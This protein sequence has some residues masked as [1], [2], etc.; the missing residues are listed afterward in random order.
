MRSI[1]SLLLCLSLSFCWGC[2]G[3]F[4]LRGG[5]SG[6][7]TFGRG[8]VAADQV[9][10]SRAGARILAQ[11]GNAVDAAVAASFTLSVV[12]PYSCGIGGGGFMVINLPDD[13]RH[14][15]VVTAINYRE[16]SAVDASYFERTGKSGTRGGAAV[17]IPGTVAGLLMAQEKYGI[18]DR[19]TVLAPAIAAARQG[20]VV[21]DHYLSGARRL[22][23]QF[24]AEP[25]MKRDFPLVW[26][27]FLREGK[28][29]R[30][31][32]ITNPKQ[33]RAL[34]RIADEGRDGF[35]KGIV[36]NSIAA[37]VRAQGGEMTVEDLAGY[38]PIECRPLVRE[39]NGYTFMTMPPPSSGGV[40]MLQTLMILEALNYDFTTA[41]MSAERAHLMAEAFKHAFAD[42]ANYLADPEFVDV[43]VNDLLDLSILHERAQLITDEI[44]D[45]DYYGTPNLAPQD[46]GTSH[47][48][49]VDPY[50]GAVACTETINHTFGSLVGVDPFG[51]V[52]NN[53]M[54]DFT[55]VRNQPN[56]FSLVQ[57]DHNLPAVGK[58]PLSSMSP[59]IVL[60]A[61]GELFA[62]AGASG[63]PRII[64][65]T[66]QTLLGAM[67]GLSAQE[68]VGA[69]RL[70]HQW[71]PDTLYAEPG[72]YGQLLVRAQEG[73]WHTLQRRRDIGNVQ[74]IVR[75]P[76]G[77]GWEA[78][79]DP[80]KGGAPAGID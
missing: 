59:T 77:R 76:R 71:L 30:G 36:A 2:G 62:I 72:L 32:R 22:I 55:T 49:V 26:E 4:N 9:V 80:R 43:P 50:G 58:R 18:L 75:E 28:V 64:S 20:F 37:I 14:G 70:H 24:N 3:A 46:G 15:R 13:P 45:P 53:E 12:R 60:D 7:D 16:T 67:A 47:L 31:D 17:A 79:C 21:D 66:T 35:Y 51:F 1:L 5:D 8:A 10:A 42:R 57:S 6:H 65:A 44:H 27:H 33:A 73:G 61:D 74:L 38:E 11:G 34:E 54:D 29:R 78:A 25:D 39:V 63:G 69:T 68:A 48:S 19:Q 41:S 40:T 52:L 56:A 23:E